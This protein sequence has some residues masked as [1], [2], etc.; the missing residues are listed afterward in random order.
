MSGVNK[1]YETIQK[2]IED[3]EIIFDETKEE[4]YDEANRKR[5][6]KLDNHLVLFEE[7]IDNLNNKT[8]DY[9][10]AF[11][12]TKRKDDIINFE[13]PTWFNN[14]RKIEH[15]I[16]VKGD[17]DDGWSIAVIEPQDFGIKTIST[18]LSEN[19][20]YSRILALDTIKKL[21]V[22][23]SNFSGNVEKHIQKS[24][25]IINSVPL[26]SNDEVFNALQEL[27]YYSLVT[28]DFSKK[29]LEDIK[30]N[31]NK[32]TI[33]RFD[34]YTNYLLK[35]GANKD[36][37]EM[38]AVKKIILDT[39]EN[40]DPVNKFEG[41]SPISYHLPHEDGTF[42]IYGRMEGYN[43]S[44]VYKMELNNNKNNDYYIK[45]TK[46]DIRHYLLF[47]EEDREPDEIIIIDK[48]GNFI[49]KENQTIKKRFI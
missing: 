42:D 28:G 12:K 31:Y 45:L 38:P 8:Y 1:L 40:G 48:K 34:A 37:I 15:I 49:E 20:N 21:R 22:L 9:E 17:I 32:S 46:K 2:M 19:N 5:I 4:Q 10:V 33:N 3:K 26:T 43:E 29:E 25:I 16:L 14:P 18:V 44:V 6:I 7:K 13:S 47:N 27:D 11:V 35:N 23:D 24:N 30:Y 36:I 41:H 39:I